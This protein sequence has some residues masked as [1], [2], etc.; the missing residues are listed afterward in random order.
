ML[1]FTN[2]PTALHHKFSRGKLLQSHR[3]E[4][5]QLS[6]ADADFSAQTK[7]PPIVEAC[8]RIDEHDGGINLTHK[9]AGLIRASWSR[10]RRRRSSRFRTRLS[11]S[12]R[13]NGLVMY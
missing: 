8:R 4:G 12:G 2:L 3:T 6:R 10:F 11:S 5:V 13:A 7:L 9:A 1:L